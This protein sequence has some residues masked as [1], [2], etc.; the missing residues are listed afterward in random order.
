MKK[1]FNV[2]GA[3]DPSK[4]YMVDLTSRLKAIREMVDRGAYFTINRGR[5]YG[6][7]TTLMALY[8][9]L[10][11]DYETVFLDFQMLGSVSYKDEPT[12]VKALSR[13]LLFSVD[14]FSDDVRRELT[15]LTEDT[16]K[17][18]SLQELFQI[19]TLWC[20]TS[21]KPVV[22]MIDEVDTATNNQI[23]LDFLAQLRAAY[24][25]RRIRPTFQSVI[26]AEIGRAHV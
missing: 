5:Q 4:D 12:F 6:K 11:Q 16:E 14:S 8:E 1:S 23:F 18:Y 21:E 15:V 10:K 2:Y 22:L 7:T 3:C 9:Y 20:K 17:V 13:S 26:L 25:S 19:F 24:L